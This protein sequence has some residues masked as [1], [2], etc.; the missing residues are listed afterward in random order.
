MMI[1]GGNKILGSVA[2]ILDQGLGMVGQ[3]TTKDSAF[4]QILEEIVRNVK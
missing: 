1:E 4:M 3:A 2:G